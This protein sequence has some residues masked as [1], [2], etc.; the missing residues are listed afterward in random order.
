MSFEDLIKGAN[1]VPEATS[2]REV[3]E[4][5]AVADRSL[6][7]ASAVGLSPEG[8]FTFAYDAALQLSTI[9][10]RCKGYRTR[11]LGHHW[12]VFSAM[13]ELMGKELEA[14]ADHFQTC[15][16]KR[17]TAIYHQSSVVTKTEAEALCREVMGFEK[18]VRR[19]L[20]T[21]YPQYA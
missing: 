13:P 6:S 5:L 14:L 15:R 9:P 7:D 2:R 12:T 1:I 16:V 17:S 10:L 19:W 20:E 21:N 3:Q 8:R 18:S 11:G 4:L